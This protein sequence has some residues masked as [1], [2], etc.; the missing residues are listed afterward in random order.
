MLS[1]TDSA[2]EVI[3]IMAGLIPTYKS[4]KL[5]QYNAQKNQAGLP[6]EERYNGQNGQYRQA[7]NTI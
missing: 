5:Q 4:A 1:S 6:E 2:E 7:V 3:K